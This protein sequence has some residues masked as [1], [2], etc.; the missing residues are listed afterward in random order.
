MI[1][2]IPST[3]FYLAIALLPVTLAAVIVTSGRGA[4]VAGASRRFDLLRVRP[5]RAL[6]TWRPFRFIVSLA[7]VALFLLIIMAGLFGVQSAGKN[8]ATVLTW[9]VW[10]ALLVVV[11]L[12]FGKA[13]CFVCPWDAIATWLERLSLWQVKRRTLSSGLPWPKPL[14][15]IYPA[16]LLF[17][18][19]TWLEL[20]YGVTTK[21]AATAYLALLLLFLALIP[22][23][24]FDRRSFCRYGCLIGRISGLYALMSGVEIRARDKGICR[25][26]CRTKDCFNGNERGYACPTYQYLAGMEKN[27]YCIFCGECIQTCPHGNVSLNVRP[28]GADLTRGIQS[29]FDEASMVI[30]MLSMTAFHGLTMTPFWGR[31]VHALGVALRVDYLVSFTLGML[32]ILA[33]LA[34]AYVALLGLSARLTESVPGLKA[35]AVRYAYALLPM[36]LFYHLAHNAS[37]FLSEAGVVVPVLSDPFG[38][39]WNLLNTAGYAPGQLASSWFVWI[40]QVILVLLGCTWSLKAAMRLGDGFMPAPRNS[41]LGRAPILIGI[42]GYAVL[43]LWLLAQPMEMRTG[44]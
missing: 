10:W 33:L 40:L 27:T 5:V 25:E 31:L 30:V 17:L 39:G 21:P 32:G 7:H 20:G 1:G 36:G 4:S 43:S 24:F 2:G 3:L 28:F 41:I 26:R 29:R 16:V 11:V 19:L 15:N 13:W 22:A 6:L 35:L 37:H 14:R 23:L 38:W 12:L 34:V 42:L 18:G 8:V 44:L 9:T